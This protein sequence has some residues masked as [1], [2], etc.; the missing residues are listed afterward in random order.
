LFSQLIGRLAAALAT[1]GTAACGCPS[2]ST[3][4]AAP[5][6]NYDFSCMGNAL[7]LTAPA[8]ITVAG[9]AQEIF[10]DMGIAQ[11]KPMPDAD[12]IACKNDGSTCDPTTNEGI[13]RSG[14]DGKYA[15][16]PK[17]TGGTP[18]DYY[19]YVEKVGNRKTFL[20]PN[21]PLHADNP[22]VEVPMM[23]NAFVAALSALG[24]PAN[25]NKSII[26]LLA[27]DCAST[28]ILD[29]DN[30]EVTISQNGQA[31][32]NLTLIDAHIFND[33]F[34]GYFFLMNVQV[35]NLD[36]SATYKGQPFRTHRIVGYPGMT[37]ETKLAPGFLPTRHEC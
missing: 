34:A 35:G 2:G 1:I 29:A 21:S 36:V 33:Q 9:L 8:T 24:I 4:D 5:V 6:F 19:L 11:M 26:G 30:V 32:P 23:Q 17:A 3:A 25:V 14:P 7:P 13:A 20:W 22:A 37:S 10:I 15:F 28:P 12:L 18:L 16:A 31:I 27:V